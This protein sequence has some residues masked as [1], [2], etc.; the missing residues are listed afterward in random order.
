MVDP[1]AGDAG[2]TPWGGG[3]GAATLPTVTGA[4]VLV[5]PVLGGPTTGAVTVGIG[6]GTGAGGTVKALT[7]GDEG[8]GR[9]VVGPMPGIGRICGSFGKTGFGG[10]VGV[11]TAGVGGGGAGGDAGAVN[12]AEGVKG[13]APGGGKLPWLGGMPGIDTTG[14]G[15]GPEPGPGRPIVGGNVRG[16]PP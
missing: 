6:A 2:P 16:P 5:I 12:P 4:G 14:P 3:P 8:D 11:A 15:A 13:P 1:V 7:G 9:S 10:T